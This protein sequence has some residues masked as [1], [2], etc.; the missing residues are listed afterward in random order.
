MADI[1]NFLTE[2]LLCEADRNSYKV[3]DVKDQKAN[4]ER[5]A[6]RFKVI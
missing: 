1:V 6:K 2:D 5:W 4:K 3:S